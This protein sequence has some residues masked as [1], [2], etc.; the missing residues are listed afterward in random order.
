MINQAV[1]Q[2][3]RFSEFIVS[4]L[5]AIGSHNNVVP[6]WLYMYM[7][8]RV[9]RIEARVGKLLD[10]LRAGTYRAPKPRTPNPD[11]PTG[12]APAKQPAKRDPRAW[13]FPNIA[14][15]VP[16][17]AR[18]PRGFGWMNMLLRHPARVNMYSGPHSAGYLTDLLHQDQEIRD[19]AKSCPALARALRPLCHMLG[20]RQA[21]LPDYLKLPK[22]V[23]KPRPPKPKRE[24]PK[25][26]KI[27]KYW[28]R[29]GPIFAERQRR[30]GK[31]T[32]T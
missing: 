17:D 10:K 29:S 12:D 8:T 31:K 19:Y 18:M 1:Y 6:V 21:L 22:R 20:I 24:K 15:T 13:V 2:S 11:A 7:H 28:M 5:S 25:K 4:L 30:F 27:Y 26:F 32:R 14:S 3:G 9:R 16:A 23:R